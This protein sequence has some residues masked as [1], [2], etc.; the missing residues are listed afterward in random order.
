MF[1]SKLREFYNFIT[2]SNDILNNTLNMQWQG[3][4]KMNIMFMAGWV[5]K[6]EPLSQR[7][8]SFV[9][10]HIAFWWQLLHCLEHIFWLLCRLI[11]LLIS[12]LHP[13]IHSLAHSGWE[14]GYEP[15]EWTGGAEQWYMMSDRSAHSHDVSLVIL[16]MRVCSFSW[17]EWSLMICSFDV[18]SLATSIASA[19][20]RR[21]DSQLKEAQLERELDAAQVTPA[22][23]LYS[24]VSILFCDVHSRSVMIL[25]RGQP[26]AG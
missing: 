23:I 17:C 19:E 10:R 26:V 5:A 14:F 15:Q 9:P 13:S 22:V 11:L 21:I 2:C 6:F 7:T 8:K 20:K 3:W 25:K 12:L 24:Y 16:M 4:H 18:F 1:G